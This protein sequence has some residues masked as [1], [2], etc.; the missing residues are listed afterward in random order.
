MK[1]IAVYGS[2]RRAEYNHSRVNGWGRGTLTHVADG[3]IEGAELINL[4][5]YPAIVPSTDRSKRVVVEVY[6]C[7][8]ALYQLIDMMEVGAGYA[9]QEILVHV[10][11]ALPPPS[12]PEYKGQGSLVGTSALAYFYESPDEL[13]RS[14]R[15][16]SGDWSHRAEAQ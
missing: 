15:I 4:G 10:D 3:W 14:P 7:P 16:T 1:R 13:S 12:P 6:D 11:P 8:E 9:A 5:S 2:L